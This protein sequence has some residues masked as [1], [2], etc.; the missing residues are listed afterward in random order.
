MQVSIPGYSLFTIGH[1]TSEVRS[2]GRVFFLNDRATL[3][4]NGDPIAAQDPSTPALT[5]AGVLT[6]CVANNGDVIVVGP[7]HS[8]TLAT[9]VALA[10]PA[11]TTVFHTGLGISW[12]SRGFGGA[13]GQLGSP[14]DNRNVERATSLLPATTVLNLFTI[15]GGPIELISIFGLVTTVLAATA[16]L[17]KLT[18]VAT[19][20]A[21]VDLCANSADLVSAA[22]GT[23]LSITGTV[24]NAMVIS[25]NQNRIAQ[26]GRLVIH[27][28]VIRVETSGTMATG[29]VKWF[30]RYAPLA[31]SAYAV[32]A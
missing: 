25:A 3:A 19:G 17:A 10:L 23:V 22:L 1:P 14:S 5:G 15:V 16:N 30:M 29:Q 24:A 11:N 20:L 18:A 2:P 4:A 26:A 9:L 28:G 27:P 13:V 7:N 32:A 21:A 8:Q 12:T 31:A 6:F